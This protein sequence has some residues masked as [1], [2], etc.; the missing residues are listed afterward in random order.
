MLQLDSKGPV[1]LWSLSSQQGGSTQGYPKKSIF[2]GV[3][4][5]K[6]TKI[7][8]KLGPSLQ[9]LNMW[10]RKGL[11]WMTETARNSVIIYF[12]YP[13]KK[14]T[15]EYH[16]H[17]IPINTKLLS[18]HETRLYQT[19]TK[20]VWGYIFPPPPSRQCSAKGASSTLRNSS[21]LTHL[22]T[23]NS[24]FW[25]VTKISLTVILWVPCPLI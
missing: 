13:L 10:M 9:Q 22:L 25:G 19:K 2:R 5:I 20:Y 24:V 7:L 14:W 21:I 16:V 8:L 15:D 4:Q 17:L 1:A 18:S 6:M 12:C 11:H 3:P 23:N